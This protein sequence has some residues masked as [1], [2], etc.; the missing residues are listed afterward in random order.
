MIIF[1]TKINYH[2]QLAEDVCFVAFALFNIVWASAYVEW[3]KRVQ[4]EYAYRWGTLG[5]ETNYLADPRPY[6]RVIFG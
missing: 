6:F 4:S 2:T 5:M 3:W 1:I